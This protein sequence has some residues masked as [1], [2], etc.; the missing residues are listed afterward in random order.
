MGRGSERPAAHTQQKLTQVP[1]G[2]DVSST[3]PELLTK[4]GLKTLEDKRKYN[5]MVTVYHYSQPSCENATPS[6]GTSS[7][8]FY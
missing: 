1:P 7:V 2:G 4:A 8:A 5:M 6:S 3:Y